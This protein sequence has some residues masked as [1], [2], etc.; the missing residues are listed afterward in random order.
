MRTVVVMV[1]RYFLRVH[2]PFLDLSRSKDTTLACH[3]V[4]EHSSQE[5]AQ[6]GYLDTA[7]GGVSRP[8]ESS[9]R[10]IYIIYTPNLG[11]AIN[12]FDQERE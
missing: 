4:A 7:T 6:R 8:G 12:V 9:E 2:R 10:R 5:E 3:Y 1:S 11:L